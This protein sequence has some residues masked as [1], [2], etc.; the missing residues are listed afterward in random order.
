MQFGDDDRLVDGLQGG[1]ISAVHAQDF[2]S[3]HCLRA[4]VMVLMCS[5][6]LRLLVMVTLRIFTV[7]VCSMPGI[8]SGGCTCVF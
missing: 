7:V 2:Q 8:G 4:Q 3:I 5:D 6:T 1:I